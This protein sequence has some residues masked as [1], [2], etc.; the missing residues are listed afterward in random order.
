MA[1][2][3]AVASAA[4][5]ITGVN[6][7]R[8]S[9]PP[10]SVLIGGINSSGASGLTNS[11]VTVDRGSPVTTLGSIRYSYSPTPA[12][13]ASG[14][15]TATNS[16]GPK[17][18]NPAL[19]REPGT[20]AIS[21]QAFST[22]TCG[23]SSSS[24]VSGGTVSVTQPT[25]NPTKELRCGLSV[26]LV[27][28]ESLSINAEDVVKTRDA[29]KAFVGALEGTGA[30]VAVVAFAQRSRVLVPYTEVTGTTIASTFNPG[31]NNSRT[32][33]APRAPGRTGRAHSM[34]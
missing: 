2:V 6:L 27:L 20:Y 17:N 26:A 23:G 9:G 7:V 22:G 21:F 15:V 25:T 30:S 18:V 3:P 33:P 13:G 31:L 5:S 24:V 8:M 19:P 4:L 29:A 16:N 12:V 34:K 32:S 11:T 28:D 10:G 14:C 1:T